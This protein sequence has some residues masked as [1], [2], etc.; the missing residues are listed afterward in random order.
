MKKNQTSD[1][2]ILMNP[3]AKA[4]RL[5]FNRKLQ[6]IKVM[7][8]HHRGFVSDDEWQQ[9]VK[10]TKLAILKNP[11]EYLGEEL[12]APELL[13]A[14]LDLIFEQFLEDVQNRAKRPENPAS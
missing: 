4:Y 2:S 13:R 9:L 10:M 6:E 3:E 1:L 11:T 12:P 8:I 14:V 7:L 5:V